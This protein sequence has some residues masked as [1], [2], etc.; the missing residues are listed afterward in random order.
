MNILFVCTS[1]KDRSPALE[2]HFREKYPQHKYRSAGINRH[3]THGKG[4]RLI[5]ELDVTWADFIAYA[6][7]VHKEHVKSMFRGD[8][9]SKTFFKHIILNLGDYDKDNMQQYVLDAEKKILEAFPEV[10]KEKTFFEEEKDR[11]VKSIQEQT[12]VLR[13]EYDGQ[14]ILEEAKNAPLE[15]VDM[16]HPRYDA[17]RNAP[18]QQLLEAAIRNY[19]KNNPEAPQW[20]RLGFALAQDDGW[21]NVAPAWLKEE[22]EEDTFKFDITKPGYGLQQ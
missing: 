3:H 17:L 13:G 22:P 14:K 5:S 4:T 12:D 11:F 18:K 6:E 2:R 16:S 7:E 1:N 19:S 9:H 15:L 20:M 10:F 8:I 21:E